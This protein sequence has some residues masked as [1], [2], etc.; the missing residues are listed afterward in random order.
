MRKPKEWSCQVSHDASICVAVLGD[1]ISVG[2]WHDFYAMHISIAPVHAR[3]VAKAI[4]RAEA[5]LREKKGG[6]HE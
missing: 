1:E 2:L 3:R 6:S 4:L 5:Y